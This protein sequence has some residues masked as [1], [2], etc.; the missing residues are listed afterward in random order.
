MRIAALDV[1]QS[2]GKVLEGT[3][4]LGRSGMRWIVPGSI[5]PFEISNNRVVVK[6][7]PAPLVAR[8]DFFKMADRCAHA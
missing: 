5:R 8:A 6:R 3:I 2:S 7:F 4:G 1:A